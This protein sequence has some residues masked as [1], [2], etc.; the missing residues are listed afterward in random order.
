MIEL[1]NMKQMRDNMMTFTVP[2]FIP[3]GVDAVA[4]LQKLKE[5]KTGWF[6][7]RWLAECV[8]FE[9]PETTGAGLDA[10]YH[11]LQALWDTTMS[12]QPPPTGDDD[13]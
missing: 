7:L 3:S 9:D 6:P 11:D 4:I 13:F 12:D 2:D 10:Y 8:R 1:Y 5:G